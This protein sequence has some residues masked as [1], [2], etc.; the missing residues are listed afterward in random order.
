LECVDGGAME[1]ISIVGIT[2]R[3]V[4]TSPLFLRLGARLRGPAGVLVGTLKR[5][6]ISNITC[7][8]PM[9]NLPSIVSGIPGHPIEGLRISGFYVHQ[10]GG[11]TAEMAA[12]VPPER[13]E[14]YPE[15]SMF[16]P[17]PAQAF[18]IRHARNITFGNVEI[19]GAEADAR[20]A[21]WLDDVDGADF[22]RIGL[23]QKGNAG[24][25]LLNNV[26]AF[27]VFGSRGVPD[28]FLPGVAHQ[29]I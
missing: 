28:T 6:T 18:F 10:K 5:V 1:D 7:D 29:L 11:G 27:R 19:A 3:D 16:G 15:P 25:F 21:F 12:L 23:P 9:S 14:A 8:G 26:A 13:E 24:A 4:R 2:M 22:F 17:L 20:P